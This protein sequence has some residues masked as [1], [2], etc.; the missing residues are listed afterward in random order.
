MTR[1]RPPKFRKKKSAA[2]RAVARTAF[3]V[4]FSSARSYYRTEIANEG[5]RRANCPVMVL[6]PRAE[7]GEATPAWIEK[8]F[9]EMD[10]VRRSDP[11]KRISI[12]ELGV[13]GRDIDVGLVDVPITFEGPLQRVASNLE[14]RSLEFL[15]TNLR[16]L[17]GLSSGTFHDQ[18]VLVT[19]LHAVRPD[20]TPSIHYHNLIFGLRKEIREDRTLIGPLDLGPMCEALG[21]RLRV[22]LVR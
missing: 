4:P 18:M 11:P 7:V 15:D 19:V 16:Y 21:R 10:E 9:G 8:L 1:Q 22:G 13:E 5:F 17:D 6:F 2:I 3:V 20:G 12:P 14:H